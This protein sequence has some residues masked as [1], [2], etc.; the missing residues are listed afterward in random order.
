M[1]MTP[2]R[3]CQ[4][5]ETNFGVIKLSVEK[6]AA[7]GFEF[8]QPSDDGHVN[9]V[10]MPFYRTEEMDAAKQQE[11]SLLECVEEMLAPISRRH[12]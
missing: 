6:M 8:D 3:A 1:A 9:V 12:G 4:G 2:E 10:N 5:L 11:L 7:R